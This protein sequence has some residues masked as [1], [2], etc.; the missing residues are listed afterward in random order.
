MAAMMPLLSRSVLVLALAAAGCAD[1]SAAEADTSAPS[2]RADRDS[3]RDTAATD[4]NKRNA[5]TGLAWLSSPVRRWGQISDGVDACMAGKGYG[6]LRWCTEDELRG[7]KTTG[8]V[9]VTASGLQCSDPPASERR[10]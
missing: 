6:R 9:V 1:R 4:V 2:Y 3:C 5:K 7:G 8:K 10:K